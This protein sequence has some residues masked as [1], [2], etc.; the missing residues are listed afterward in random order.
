MADGG[1]C[2]VHGC[3]DLPSSWK[4]ESWEFQDHAGEVVV[5]DGTGLED[6]LEATQRETLDGAVR[7]FVGRV[8]TPLG[9]THR[10]QHLV[11]KR[12]SKPIKQRYY[13]ISPVL[14]R[15]MYAGLDEMLQAGVVE[16]SKSAWSSPVVMIRKK[17]G[18]YRFCVDYRKVNAVTR[19]DAYPLPYVNHILDRL[20][21][22]RYLSSLY[23]KSAYWQV[24]LSEESN[25]R[26]AFTV[27]ALR[28]GRLN[29][30]VL[31]PELDKHVFVYFD[32]IIVCSAQFDEH[33]ETL[34]RVIKKLKEAGLSLNHEK[35]QFCRPELRS[36]RPILWDRFRHRYLIV[37]SDYFTK[38]S[39]LF[40]VRTVTG[41]TLSRVL[42]EEVFMVYGVPRQLICDNG[43]QYAARELRGMLQSYGVGLLFNA[44]YHSQHNP[45]ERVNR[46]LSSALASYVGNDHRK[47]DRQLPQIGLALRTAVHEATGYA[48]AYLNIGRTLK[49]AADEYGASVRKTLRRTGIDG[50]NW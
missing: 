4:G 42:E 5:S 16:P 17:E 24:S 39:L 19:R 25:E 23:V 15:A 40:P 36:L 29:D 22:A 10:V 11:D 26:T 38:Y 45:V 3:V 20:R 32:D 44:L 47:W 30:Q 31:G 35:R 49:K 12:D 33:V 6:H 46:V 43:P 37:V 13:P 50:R 9:C 14:K 41:K 48:P 2:V 28:P 7:E 1:R 34:D 18:S 8:G 27:P 21:N